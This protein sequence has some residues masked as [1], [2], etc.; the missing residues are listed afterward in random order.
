M[1]NQSIVIA[2]GN[3]ITSYDIL[4]GGYLWN[5]TLTGTVIEM[6]IKNQWVFALTVG[7]LWQIGPGGFI[8]MS[9][10]ISSSSQKLT[11]IT[12]PAGTST[13]TWS[14]GGTTF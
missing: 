8:M 2:T 4:T 6:K 12:T 3:K 9:G 13:M 11:I 14:I 1:S 10:T 7:T 5:T